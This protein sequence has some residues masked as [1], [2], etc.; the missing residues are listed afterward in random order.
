MYRDRAHASPVRSAAAFVEPVAVREV[1]EISEVSSAAA[2]E[3]WA[4]RATESDSGPR[5]GAEDEGMMSRAWD[6]ADVARA[7]T[8]RNWTIGWRSGGAGAAHAMPAASARRFM[9]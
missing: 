3:T 2:G 7:Y 4:A 1:A 9:A 5:P 8:W 6:D